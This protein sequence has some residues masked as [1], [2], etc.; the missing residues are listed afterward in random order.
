MSQSEKL[1]EM[2]RWALDDILWKGQMLIITTM[3][4]TTPNITILST[5]YIKYKNSIKHPILKSY[6]LVEFWCAV[7]FNPVSTQKKMLKCL[8]SELME[9]LFFIYFYIFIFLLFLNIIYYTFFV[10][11]Y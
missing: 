1:S 9:K 11:C 10:L 8:E 2:M 7:S 4:F 6:Y 5:I 3:Y